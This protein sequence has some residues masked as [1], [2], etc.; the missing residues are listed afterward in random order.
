M[1]WQVRASWCWFDI[2]CLLKPRQSGFKPTSSKPRRSGKPEHHGVGL[3]YDHGCSN[4]VK[5]DSDQHHQNHDAPAS[6]AQ[7]QTKRIQNNI[8]KTMMLWQVPLK[9]SQSEFRPTSSKP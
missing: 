9:P 6:T 5:A 4:P 3:I 7:T 2:S 1:F 8:V